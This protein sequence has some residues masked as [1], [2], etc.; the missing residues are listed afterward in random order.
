ML[1]QTGAIAVST[2]LLAI[3]F[4][5]IAYDLSGHGHRIRGLRARAVPRRGRAFLCFFVMTDASRPSG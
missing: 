1:R 2:Q 5:K 4:P 3:G